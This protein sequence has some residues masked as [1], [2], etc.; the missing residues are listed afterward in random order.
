MGGN[1]SHLK[2]GVLFS[3]LLACQIM[4]PTHVTLYPVG[5]LTS[6]LPITA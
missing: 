2:L 4:N 5:P 3:V 1:V 6:A